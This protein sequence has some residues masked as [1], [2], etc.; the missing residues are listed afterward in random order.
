MGA[1]ISGG[2]RIFSA[3]GSPAHETKI[4]PAAAITVTVTKQQNNFF[5]LY[6]LKVK[7]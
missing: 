4:S 3:S 6:R 1:A 2:L 7:T 5:I